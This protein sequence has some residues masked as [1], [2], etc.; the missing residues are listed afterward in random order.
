MMMFVL[1]ANK[2]DIGQTNAEMREK[3]EIIKFN[4]IERTKAEIVALRHLLLLQK[5]ADQDQ[6][7]NP[8][9][10][11]TRNLNLNLNRSKKN[12]SK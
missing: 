7:L 1:T 3:K 10:N 6:S 9:Q 5:A 12:K 8:V 11:L 2:R 4:K